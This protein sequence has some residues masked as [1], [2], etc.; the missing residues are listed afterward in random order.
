MVSIAAYVIECSCRLPS[1]LRGK[2]RMVYSGC[3]DGYT[4]RLEH[5]IFSNSFDSIQPL[6]ATGIGIP[7]IKLSRWVSKLVNLEKLY[8]AYYPWQQFS[9]HQPLQ[10]CSELVLWL[11]LDPGFVIFFFLI[12]RQLMLIWLQVFGLAKFERYS[13]FL[14]IFQS[15][16]MSLSH[17]LNGLLPCANLT[18][19]RGTTTSPDPHGRKEG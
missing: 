17:I 19:L 10:W 8:P 11:R 5:I 16:L 13:S 14:H 1:W 9:L 2:D 12:W 6:V 3:R 18:E 7:G 15:K 4:A